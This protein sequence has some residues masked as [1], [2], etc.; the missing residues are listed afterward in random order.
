[1]MQ[2]KWIAGTGDEIEKILC[3]SIF[4]HV[5]NE[6]KGQLQVGFMLCANYLLM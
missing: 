6:R 1:M 4:K 2:S 5:C 3:Y